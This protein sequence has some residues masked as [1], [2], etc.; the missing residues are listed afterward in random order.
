MRFPP[1]TI[2][3]QKRYLQN[4][5]DIE[6]VGPGGETALAC[7]AV[8][9]HLPVVELLLDE[10]AS[11]TCTDSLGR[12]PLFN[13]VSSPVRSGCLEVVRRLLKA[14]SSVTVRDTMGNLPVHGAAFGGNRLV[15][16][17]VLEAG[18]D[19]MSRNGQGH[20]PLMIAT[21]NG[22]IGLFQWLLRQGRN[23]VNDTCPNGMSPLFIAADYSSA[24][25]VEA[26][27]KAGGKPGSRTIDGWTPLHAAT[28]LGNV[29]M[30]RAL[31]QAGAEPDAPGLLDNT[32]LNVAGKEGQ[33][34]AARELMR[35]GADPLT[36][37][38][39]GASPLYNA[40]VESNSSIA[41]EMLKTLERR[42]E[43]EGTVYP[44]RASRV[45]KGL[46][47]SD[48]RFMALVN[49]AVYGLEFKS[50]SKLLSM[51]AL[52]PFADE[53]GD[54][55]AAEYIEL[56]TP[57]DAGLPPKDP[58]LKACMHRMIARRVAFTATS[59]LWPLVLSAGKSGGGGRASAGWRRGMAPVSIA[60]CRPERRRHR[61]LELFPAFRRYCDKKGP[62]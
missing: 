29:R 43:E 5:D 30:I 17:A 3:E 26:V 48:R 40:V 35:A 7:A 58:V 9:G 53:G 44:S 22:H 14:G 38:R 18:G 1:T 55:R 24:E 60:R 20:T 41:V 50:L 33:L 6:G 10:G 51:G 45:G 39:K 2:L 61:Q 36:V 34:E 32:P 31:I 19:V 28:R 15:M 25:M 13:A 49:G 21:Q 47:R 62:A 12:T 37:C 42:D 8:A 16:K 56:V 46:F 59:W 4:G 54:E 23:D 27:I 11:I 57:A 52:D